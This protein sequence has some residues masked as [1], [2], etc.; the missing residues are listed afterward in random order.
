MDQLATFKN[1][2]E[3]QNL[4]VKKGDVDSLNDL[5]V[6]LEDELNQQGLHLTAVHRH[7]SLMASD[8]LVWRREVD[9]LICS[10]MRRGV[11]LTPASWCLSD[12][13][14]I[15]C[16]EYARDVGFNA[17]DVNLNALICEVFVRMKNA[18]I[19]GFGLTRVPNLYQDALGRGGSEVLYETT[20]NGITSI[21]DTPLEQQDYIE[22]TW[23][24]EA[25]GPSLVTSCVECR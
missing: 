11:A 12:D 3:V 10:P 22:T 17:K 14:S 19:V 25:G 8:I 2:E 4:K 16:Y 18:G 23:R 6:D 21:S 13:G 24:I 1:I 20:R 7:H 5:L 15:F 9:A